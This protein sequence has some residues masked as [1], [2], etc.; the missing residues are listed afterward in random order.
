MSAPQKL[1]DAGIE[2]PEA[3]KKGPGVQEENKSLKEDVKT[4]KEELEATKKGISR[5]SRKDVTPQKLNVK[6]DFYF[7]STK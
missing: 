5:C 7:Y 2:V 3:G 6:S 4:L 1:H